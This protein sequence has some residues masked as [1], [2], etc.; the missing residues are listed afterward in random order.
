MSKKIF[1][2]HQQTL[3][4]NQTDHN[5]DEETYIG[6]ISIDARQYQEFTKSALEIEI[7]SSIEDKVTLLGIFGRAIATII[8]DVGIEP[9]KYAKILCETCEEIEINTDYE[10]T[11]QQQKSS[12]SLYEELTDCGV[13][14]D[15][16]FEPFDDT[17]DE[18]EQNKP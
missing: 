15:D 7:T 4:F 6:H 12:S 5:A 3:D 14:F 18:E 16:T 2:I 17:F 8:N 11:F 9:E 1:G 13:R 10:T